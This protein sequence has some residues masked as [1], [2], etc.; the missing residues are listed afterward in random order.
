[1]F[2]LGLGFTNFFEIGHGE[3][4]TTKKPRRIDGLPEDA[5][6]IQVVAGGVHTLALTEDGRVSFPVVNYVSS[7]DRIFVQVFS[8][9]INEKGTVPTV[10]ADAEGSVSELGLVAFPADFVEQYGKVRFY[11]YHVLIVIGKLGAI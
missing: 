2:R 5:V 8:C 10:N 3:R 11:F 6:F 1:L 7:T 4:L 9:G